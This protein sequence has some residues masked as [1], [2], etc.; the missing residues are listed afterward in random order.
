MEI[1]IVVIAVAMLGLAALVAAGRFGE[2][3]AEPVRD[4]Y[5]QP[6]PEGALSAADL[7]G[8]RFGIAPLGYDMSQVDELVA[9]M[10][11]ELDAR[12]DAKAA[13]S[14]PAPEGRSADDVAS[15]VAERRD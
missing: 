14:P 5:Q 13:A 15:T 8:I 2:M 4:T 10:A 3:Q 7:E 11:R 1:V 12:D 6:V 9:R